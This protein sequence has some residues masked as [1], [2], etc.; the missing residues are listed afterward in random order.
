MTTT[1]PSD[2]ARTGAQ[3]RRRCAAATACAAAQSTPNRAAAVPQ[4]PA[5][6]GRRRPGPGAR[7]ARRRPRRAP[8]E[9]DDQRARRARDREHAWRSPRLAPRRV[10]T[11]PPPAGPRRWRC[12][13]SSP[14]S[15]R[16]AAGTAA[17][18]ATPTRPPV[19]STPDL[20]TARRRRPHLRAAPTGARPGRAA[21]HRA[22]P[23]RRSAPAPRPRSTAASA[24]AS[25]RTRL[26]SATASS[27]VAAPCSARCGPSLTTPCRAR[28][29]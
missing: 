3:D 10:L 29:R 22:G 1:E 25:T 11:A 8:G 6:R 7:R 16:R 15:G 19:V 24:T 9:D 17:V 5:P 20:R 4:R 23:R 2:N 21:G 13:A 18:T 26:G 28:T 27:A 12:G 14:P